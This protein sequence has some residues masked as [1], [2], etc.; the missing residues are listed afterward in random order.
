MLIPIV[1]GISK[2]RVEAVLFPNHANAEY[3]DVSLQSLVFLLL[4]LEVTYILRRAIS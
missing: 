3:Q 4:F 2:L 1:Q